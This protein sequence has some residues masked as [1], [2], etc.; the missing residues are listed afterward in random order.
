MFD[1]MSTRHTK[2]KARPLLNM[3]EEANEKK[4]VLNNRTQPDDTAGELIICVHPTLFTPYAFDSAVIVYPSHTK[5]RT[6]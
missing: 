6:P 2:K 3:D 1:D 5:K 4:M